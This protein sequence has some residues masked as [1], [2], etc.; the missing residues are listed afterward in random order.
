VSDKAGRHAARA[1]PALF[2]GHAVEAI[3]RLMAEQEED[4]P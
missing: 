2:C 3:R 1:A 4:A